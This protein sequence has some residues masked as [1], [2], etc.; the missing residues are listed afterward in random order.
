MKFCFNCGK[1]L[2]DSSVFCSECGAK[3]QI[4]KPAQEA[5]AQEAP[6]QE[7]PIGEAP[8]QQAPVQ[9]VLQAQPAQEARVEVSTKGKVMGFVSF[10]L[11]V[12]GLF[13]STIT[14]F[15]ALSAVDSYFAEG[16]ASVA[17][18][19]SIIFIITSI[20]GMVFSGIAQR[21]GNTAVFARLGKIFGIIGTVL[22]GLSFIIAIG[23]LA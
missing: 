1:Q 7:A 10:G 5:P 13:F 17:I 18:V 19:Y 3:Q 2:E 16:P 6:A 9:E 4:A 23:A 8:D 14:F 12:F 15:L 11:A 22:F 20:L 21:E